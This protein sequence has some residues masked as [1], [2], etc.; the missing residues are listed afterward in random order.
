MT[1]T[2][3]SSAGA[4]WP[5]LTFAL[6]DKDIRHVSGS[7]LVNKVAIVAVKL[8]SRLATGVNRVRNM[9]TYKVV[10]VRHGESAWNAENRFCGWFDADLAESGVAEA[11]KAAQV[12]SSTVTISAKIVVIVNC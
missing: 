4:L 12:A 2:A 11:K 7:E 10:M 8:F 3:H 6:P 1:A 5:T 9:A